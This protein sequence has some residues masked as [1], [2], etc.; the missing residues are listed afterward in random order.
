MYFSWATARDE[1]HGTPSLWV[2][3]EFV[4]DYKNRYSQVEFA[5]A[6]DGVEF[7]YGE[8]SLQFR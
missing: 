5:A 1:E 2:L 4:V 7:A 8:W 3:A 6:S